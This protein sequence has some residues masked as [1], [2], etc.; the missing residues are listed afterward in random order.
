MTDLQQLRSLVLPEAQ[1]QAFLQEVRGCLPPPHYERVQAMTELLPELLQL[2]EQKSMSIGRLR[3][4]VFGAT[5]ESSRKVCGGPPKEPPPRAKRRGHGRRGQRTYTGAVRVPV[6]HPTHKD[7]DCCPGCGKGKLR[8]QKKPATVVT[9]SA[10]PSVGA[11]VHEMERLR[12][13]G[14]GTVFTAAT[15]A[16]VGLEKYDANVGVMVGLLRYGSGMPFLRLERLQENVGVPLPS[17]IQW[18]QA[19]RAAEALGPVVD[20]LIYLGAQAAMVYTDD[21]PMRV[22]ALRQQ[23]QAET[24]PERTGIFTTGIVCEAGE[25]SI[26]LFFTGR[27][28]AGENLARVL[29]EREAGLDAPLHMSDGLACNEPKGH[30]TQPC[31][32]NI[33]ARRNFVDI[34]G[35]FPEE[36]QKVIASFAVIYR[37]EA[38]CRAEALDPE[39][40]LKLHQTESGPEMDRLKSRFTGQLA[41][42]K[43]E[44]NSGLGQAIKYM[45]DR[46]EALTRFLVVA[47]APLDNNVTERLL[48][49]SIMHRKNS[50]HY[51]TTR[52]AEVGDAF[53]SVIQTCVANRINSFNYMVAVV[54][55]QR[56][57]KED[58]GHW[59]P[60]NYQETLAAVAKD[61]RPG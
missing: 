24:D 41:E 61:S 36:C 29:E 2:L 9:V 1:R 45:L 51:R 21:T 8:R 47:G 12:C 7:G 17:S 60:W 53:M 42:K 13:D 4:L 57:V 11:Q 49:T 38:R 55:N 19:N 56:A 59:L 54:K 27:K 40:R 14:C 18:E 22:G 31:K 23:I 34:M 15:P 26:R 32:C 5:T 48:K 52:G 39:A 10:Q 16:G 28:H 30:P 46:W 25:H 44:P 6:P 33:H 43:V 37:V 50:L 58:P 35:A 3:Q 20:H